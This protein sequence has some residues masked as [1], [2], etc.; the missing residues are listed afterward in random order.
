[1]HGRC[2][3]MHGYKVKRW[4]CP[5]MARSRT[6]PG[7]SHVT[8]ALTGAYRSVIF[9]LEKERS[10]RSVMFRKALLAETDGIVE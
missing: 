1:M 4:G 10:N 2:A 6:K 5:A 7:G 3:L 9:N 8:G